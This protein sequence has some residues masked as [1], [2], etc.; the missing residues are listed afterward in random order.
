MANQFEKVDIQ[1][2]KALL[3]AVHRRGVHGFNT[4]KMF[5]FIKGFATA[6]G[7]SQTLQALIFA[8]S[9]HAEQK[10]KSG[11]PYINHPYTMALHAISLGIATDNLLATILLHDV[12]EDCEGV[13]LSDLPVGPEV[14]E[15]VSLLT[16]SVATH[17]TKEQ[18]LQRYYSAISHN[19]YASFTKIFDRC[20]NVSS[21]AGTFT[22]FKLD[23]YIAE[24]DK[25]VI[26][27]I[28]SAKEHWPDKTN[29][30]FAL[31]YQI[32][33]VTDAIAETYVCYGSKPE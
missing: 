7:Y 1:E 27:L 11:E 20:H 9:K 15:A 3:A 5:T 6:G 4:G 22:A 29:F 26:P 32:I 31:Q 24:T 19:K 18:A 13:R 21:M 10:R 12:L 28:D 16:F 23:Q 17:E 8:R 33:A 2:C 14:R 30:L 25:F